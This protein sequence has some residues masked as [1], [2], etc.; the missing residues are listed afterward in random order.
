MGVLTEIGLKY[1]TDKAT[2]HNFTDWYEEK[3]S[4]ISPKTIL[5]I[6][7]K[8]GS[9][10]KMWRDYYGNSVVIGIDINKPIV[11]ENAICL[12]LDGTNEMGFT[13]TFSNIKFDLIIDDGSHF[14][15]HQMASFN[16]LFEKYLASN[17]I[18]ILEDLH[19]SF[20][21]E[22]IDTKITTYDWLL[23][24]GLKFEI[25]QKDKNVFHDSMTAII[26]K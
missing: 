3:L 19:T 24:S 14:T 18:Y 13:K 17:G 7:V 12:Q 6:G 23:N 22:Y 5:E 16:F 25:F 20:L 15:S 26:Y 1:G 21:S 9:S 2:Y 4:V 10:L 8:E 11:I